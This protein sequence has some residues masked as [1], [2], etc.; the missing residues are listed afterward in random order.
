M[1]DLCRHEPCIN[2][3][4]NAPNPI[5]MYTCDCCGG[6]IYDGEIY[7]KISDVPDVKTLIICEGCIRD[8]KY[9]AEYEE[10]ERDA[11]DIWKER[12][13]QRMIDEKENNHV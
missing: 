3:C 8:A 10:Y 4:P 7:Y 13:E 6:N 1:C 12:E 5:E 2:N 9:Y 11:M